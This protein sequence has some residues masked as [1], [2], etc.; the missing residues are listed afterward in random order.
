MN[1]WNNLELDKHPRDRERAIMD[2]F[3]FDDL[4]LQVDCNCEV[5][6]KAAVIAE[7]KA[8]L[9]LSSADDLVELYADDIV[10]I[11]TNRRKN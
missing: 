3:T 11:V 6:T 4:I 1:D 9:E 5:L 2:R 7:F 8:W 10:K